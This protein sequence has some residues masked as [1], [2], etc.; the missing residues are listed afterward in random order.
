MKYYDIYVTRNNGDYTA[1]VEDQ[2]NYD[3]NRFYVGTIAEDETF[4]I[5]VD[6]MYQT[7][8]IC[9]L[10][11]P[12]VDLYNLDSVRQFSEEWTHK[13]D[14]FCDDE[15]FQA[16]EAEGREEEYVEKF[17]EEQNYDKFYSLY[18]YKVAKEY[19]MD[20]GEIIVELE[21]NEVE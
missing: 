13:Y 10:D 7:T 2:T 9:S 11:N 20:W 4:R 6:N 8:V 17:L 16:A 12:S 21:C 18:E 3:I 15:E 19:K 5:L 14:R 1:L